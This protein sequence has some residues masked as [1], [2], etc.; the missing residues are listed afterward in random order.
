[1]KKN[2]EKNTSEEQKIGLRN[3]SK[4]VKVIPAKNYLRNV[5]M[6]RTHRRISETEVQAILSNLDT[7]HQMRITAITK[8]EW[9]EN[10]LVLKHSHKEHPDNVHDKVYTIIKNFLPN[11]VELGDRDKNI[12]ATF[13]KSENFACLIRCVHSGKTKDGKEFSTEEYELVIYCP[14]KHTEQTET[15]CLSNKDQASRN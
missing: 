12:P 1:M 13:N 6:K 8:P 15:S 5:I 2:E 10:K 11:N 3:A 14:K 7:R 9:A 4:N